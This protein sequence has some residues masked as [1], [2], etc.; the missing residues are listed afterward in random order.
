MRTPVS[1][2]FTVLLAIAIASAANVTLTPT[3]I[4]ETT[5]VWETININNYQGSTV[6]NEIEVETSLLPIVDAKS[7]TGWTT[8]QNSDS[9]VWKDGSIETNVN[10]AVFE[11]KVTAP[12][13]SADTLEQAIVSLD[14]A[15]KT[16]NI[17]ILNDPTPPDITNIKP[18]DYA[19]A[20]NPAHT[21]SAT[22]TDPETTVSQVT[23]T[24]NDCANGTDTT[25]TLT[26]NNDEYIG[27]ANFAGYDEGE[28]ACY[29]FTATNTPGETATKTGELLFDG[30]PPTV[31]ISAP[32][33]YAT[34]STISK[35]TA[36]DNVATTLN[37]KIELDNSE[38][39]S[40]TATSGTE[41]TETL[42]LSNYTEGSY[43]WSVTC[44]DGVGLTATR[45]QAII[46]DT[47]P[48][49]ITLA[50]NS[51][52]SR[53]Q[54][55]TFT[56]TIADTVG[57]ASVTAT[58]E[59]QNITLT[60]TGNDYTGSI[61]SNTLGEKTL[62]LTAVDAV[63]HTKTETKTITAV[64]NHQI[65][66]TLTPSS[67][68]KGTT[69][70]ASGKLTTDGNVTEDD[71]KVKTPIQDFTAE[72]DENNEYSIT[73]TAP[74]PG[75]YDITTEY[76][77]D[78]HTYTAEAILRVQESSQSRGDYSAGYPPWD[79]EPS[80]PPEEPPAETSSNENNEAEPEQPAEQPNNPPPAEYEPL[81]PEEPRE[82]FTPKATG[83]FN[84]GKTIKWLSLLLALALIAGL[85]VYA[86]KKRPK[87]DSGIDWDGY[88]KGK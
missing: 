29:T 38:L 39:G 74:I 65:T 24:W 85:G 68:T 26:K 69:V 35:F 79:G 11:F 88:F 52:L 55:D 63:G 60:Q 62:E 21:V 7:Y 46:L 47:Q 75:N 2:L 54:T 82:A 45:S 87:D 58:F 33:T 72:L 10:N 12:N 57:L 66:L 30:T 16:F 86:Y 40:Y 18:N 34:E 37:C 78:E 20:N 4:Y 41:K 9:A 67:T 8:V 13:V 36:T 43:T 28:K 49:A 77:E 31:T 14:S 53:T 76:I 17:S 51:F 84:L 19:K 80:N 15:D 25:I 50:Y 5:S 61:S 22:V 83:V 44:E 32:T 70:T 81:P 73:F 42:D 6:I 27:T 48:P 59:G 56:A 71:V 3:T 23:Y 64:P 1:I